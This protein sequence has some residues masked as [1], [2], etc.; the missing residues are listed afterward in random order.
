MLTR[1]DRLVDE[2]A[3]LH[4]KLIL[5]VGRPGC[6]KT[7]LLAMLANR[8]GAK[9]MNVGAALGKRLSLLPQR[10]RAL[11]AFVA[12]R[13]LADEHAS[14]DLLLLDNI[15]LLFDQMLKLDPLD[16]LKRHAHAR[17]VVAVWPGELRGGRLIYAEIGHPEYQDYGPEG[18]VLFEMETA[19]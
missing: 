9:V 8:R 19:G 2:I 14:G 6:G 1:L 18:V 16:L 7:S 15:E 3:A 5:L 4:S 13:E 17:R 10:Q 12:M 11:Q